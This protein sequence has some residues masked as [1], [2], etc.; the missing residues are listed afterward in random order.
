MNKFL[1]YIFFLIFLSNC[2]LAKNEIV[3]KKNE[4]K[5]IFKKIEPI[6]NELN[7]GLVINFSESTLEDVFL[8]NNTNNSGNINFQPSFEKKHL[9]KFKKNKKI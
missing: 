8:N 2:N 3:E 9:F 1:L 7:P 4:N 6:K 5:D